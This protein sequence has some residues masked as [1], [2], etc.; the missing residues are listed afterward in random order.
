AFQ[1]ESSD[2]QV[3]VMLEHLSASHNTSGP[4]VLAFGADVTVDDV[5]VE[6][7]LAAGVV[8]LFGVLHI[9]GSVVAGIQ[10]GDGGNGPSSPYDGIGVLGALSQVTVAGSTIRD[11]AAA[12][13]VLLDEESLNPAVRELDAQ[14]PTTSGAVTKST[15]SGNGSG[16]LIAYQAGL[17]VDDSTLVGNAGAGAAA[18]GP[19]SSARISNVTVSGTRPIDGAPNVGGIVQDNSSVSTDLALTPTDR[20]AVGD[21]V[22]DWGTAHP[23]TM[24][25]AARR[26][27]A[28]ADPATGVMVTG[29]IVA[30]Q[31]AGVPDCFGTVA[32]GGYNLSGDKANSCSFSAGEHDLVK[33]DPKLGPLADNG[34]PTST[35]LLGKGSPAIDAIPGGAANCA[36]GTS[37][38]RGVARPQPAGNACDIGAVELKADPIVIAPDKL[39]RGTVG[40]KYRTQL[41]ATGGA[42][43]TYTFSLADGALP[44]GLTMDADGTISGTPTTAGTFSF[45]V[46]VNDPV[47]KAYTIVIRAVP[48]SSHNGAASDNGGAAP[49]AAT[50]APVQPMA[51]VGAGTVFAGFLLLIGAGLVGRRPG[52]HRADG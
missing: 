5:R 27:A 6:D 21:A 24:K 41:N 34:G 15:V 18:F 12:G 16:G 20:R 2:S 33:T 47:L 37:D 40:D 19:R 49:I 38:Q 43:P 28:D 44:D 17:T 26:L 48:S 9:S 13:L 39:P 8:S 22:T 46:S 23:A 30:D 25:R 45:T 36:P 42:Y 11:N 4:G 3:A 50:G 1:I 29:T 51:V 14:L 32:D 52:R 10:F 35:Q 7:D 31:A